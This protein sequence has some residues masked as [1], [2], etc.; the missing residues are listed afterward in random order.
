MAASVP[1][2]GPY[3]LNEN[4]ASGGATS[5]PFN[6]D[7]DSRCPKVIGQARWQN[8]EEPIFQLSRGLIKR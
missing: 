3:L 5:T 4:E 2:S 1:C 8:K 7:Y 6:N